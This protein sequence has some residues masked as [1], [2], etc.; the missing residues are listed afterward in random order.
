MIS[1]NTT[2]AE[3]RALL[4]HGREVLEF[5]ARKQR[6]NMPAR[7]VVIERMHGGSKWVEDAFNALLAFRL[8]EPVHSKW[9]SGNTGDDG[10]FGYRLTQRGWEI[11]GDMPIWMEVN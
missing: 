4:G 8:I 1:P 11:A 6:I 3:H 2:E 5:I 9:A 10:K 7:R